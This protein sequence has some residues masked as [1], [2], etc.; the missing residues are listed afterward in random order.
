MNESA[1]SATLPPSSQIPMTF[2]QILDRIYRLMRSNLKL[3]VG[4]A[5]VPA[6]AFIPIIG[7]AFAVAFV[8][9]IAQQ[10]SH[11]DPSALV[12]RLIP[13]FFIVSL[14]SMAVFALYL[15]ASIHA[16]S[17]VHM[18]LRATLSEAYSVAWKRGWR[19]LWLMFLGYL[20]AF[21][22]I[23]VAELVIFVPMGLFSMN[24]ATPPPAFFLLIPLGILLFIAALV[25]GVIVALRLSLAFPA[26]IAEDLKAWA[27]IRRSGRLTQGAKGRIFLVLLVIYALA[28]AAEMVVGI[29]LMVIFG[30][31]A[32]AAT[33]LHIQLASVAGIVGAGLAVVF[34]SA[35]LF[36]WT[37]LIWSAYST[38][39]A[40]IYHDQR[41]R[42]DGPLQATSPAGVLA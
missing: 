42:I 27:A 16:A 32:L 29:V 34:L 10:E 33:A 17:Q 14:L 31:G 13:L 35:L 19:Y 41:L 5:A 39:F 7:L 15:A 38:A 23:L 25:Y 24:K 2:G 4:I 9:M 12:Y 6:A 8:P 21:A 37:A 1:A 40:V 22:P 26:S 30:I 3:F 18:G 11:S 28:Y 36:L 20:I